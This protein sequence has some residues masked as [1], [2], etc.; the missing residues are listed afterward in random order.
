MILIVELVD[1][2]GI[3]KF[4]LVLSVFLVTIVTA[5]EVTNDS[6]NN[7]KDEVVIQSKGTLVNHPACK[8]ALL[9]LA[10]GYGFQISKNI[11]FYKKKSRQILNP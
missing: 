5:E 7:H 11:Q 10:H 9:D 8:D 6:T 2:M 3:N 1:T 4:N